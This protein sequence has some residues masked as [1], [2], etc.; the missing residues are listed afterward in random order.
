MSAGAF[1]LVG[2]I[3]CN[4]RQVLIKC[5]RQYFRV[6]LPVWEAMDRIQ[7]G[8]DES[9]VEASL[10]NIY[11]VDAAGGKH[12]ILVAVDAVHAK[13]SVSRA[14]G[15]SPRARIEFDISNIASFAARV[16][17]PAITAPWVIAILIPA[18]LVA[19]YY[20][21]RNALHEIFGIK[22]TA[23]IAI[24]VA[25][26][27]FVIMALHE[28]SHA[29]VAVR[30]G[31]RSH[32]VGLGIFFIFPVFYA[33]VSEIWRLSP[34]KRIEVNLAG[35]SIQLWIGL[36]VCLLG[37]IVP[38]NY[39]PFLIYLGMMNASSIFLNLIPF[40]RLDGYWVLVDLSG[41]SALQKSG[42]DVLAGWL[43][44]K[45]YRGALTPRQRLFA[46]FYTITAAIFYLWVL[47]ATCISVVELTKIALHASDARS[48]A[49]MLTE[50]PLTWLFITY[51]IATVSK[52]AVQAIKRLPIAPRVA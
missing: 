19:Q 25:A 27:M 30:H 32:K 46:G 5:D 7:S 16:V 20:M 3:E 42:F 10:Y 34:K 1:T 2:E 45:I 8:E 37:F 18:N 17:R 41:I 40:A 48:R 33:D 51:L 21:R 35:V 38:N 31:C 9:L 4:T 26:A 52:I 28:L 13:M 14:P 6:G 15:A 43:R 47:Y 12:P 29:A 11:P 39:L 23:M 36:C 50:Y 49:T 22:M 44:V 24:E